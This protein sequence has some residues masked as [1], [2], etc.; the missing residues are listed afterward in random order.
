MKKRWIAFLV[1]ALLATASMI[2]T[3][4]ILAGG[5]DAKPSGLDKLSSRVAAILGLDETVVDDA[6]K[7]ARS[8][9]RDEALRAKLTV[10]EAKLAAMVEDGLLSQEHADEKLKA[11]QSEPK[12]AAWEKK[13]TSNDRAL[14]KKLAAMVEEGELTQEEADEKLRWILAKKAATAKSS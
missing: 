7:Q 4:A 9:L 2:S 11:F 1:V 12:T 10:Y 8:E 5:D 6:I 14:Q 13:E 3:T